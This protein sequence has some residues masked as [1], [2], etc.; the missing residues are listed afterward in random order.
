ALEKEVGDSVNIQAILNGT[1][2]WRGRQQQILALQDKVI[3]A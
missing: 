2:N 3:F 1:V